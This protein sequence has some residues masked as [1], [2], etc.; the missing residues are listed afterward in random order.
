MFYL[1]FYSIQM[2]NPSYGPST[3]IIKR[4]MRSQLIDDYH[5]PDIVIN[6]LNASLYVNSGPFAPPTLPQVAF[7]RFLKFMAEYDW[8]LQPVYL[9]FGEELPSKYLSV[10]YTANTL[11]L[12]F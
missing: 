12:V 7:L 1:S 5:F 8:N 2:Q 3:A 11:K 9:N 4:W 10:L 6:M